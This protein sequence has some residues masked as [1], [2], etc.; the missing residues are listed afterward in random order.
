MACPKGGGSGGSGGGKYSS[1]ELTQNVGSLNI[2][3]AKSVFNY[4]TEH[5]GITGKVWEKGSQQR[6]YVYSGG[7]TRGYVDIKTGNMSADSTSVRTAR[8]LVYE[9]MQAMGVLKKPK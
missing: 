8:R 9:Q 3:S 1:E 4:K 5:D 7:Q 2:D 6:L